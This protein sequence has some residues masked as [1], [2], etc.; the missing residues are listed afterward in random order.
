MPPNQCP[1]SVTWQSFLGGELPPADRSAA[2]AHLAG[3][4]HC[5]ESLIALYDNQAGARVEETAP[6]SLKRRVTR[7]PVHWIKSP[8]AYV[9][10]A[11]A[12]TVVIAVGLSIFVYRNVQS[13]SA[14][15]PVGGLRRSNGPTNDLAL[16][17][18]PNG[19]QLNP[20]PVDF[21]WS[22]A[23]NSARYEL[24]VTDEKGDIIIQEETLE[25]HLVIDIAKLR[26][27]TQRNYY[28]SVSARLPDGT[29]RES[30]IAGFTL[31]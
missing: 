17:G 23:G 5:R 18:P 26:L 11:L 8:R 9:P 21:H 25:S 15:P 24:T 6:S 10:L 19:A 13:P 7:T 4:W 20:G 3:C 1:D 16:A 22:D 2:E 14:A 12:A 30:G 31:R 29:N 27:S 28:W